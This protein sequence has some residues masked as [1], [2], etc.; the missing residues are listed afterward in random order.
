MEALN[1]NKD[2]E[3]EIQQ[4]GEEQGTSESTTEAEV[5]PVPVVGGMTDEEIEEVVK[6]L[7]RG[8]ESERTLAYNW[9]IQQLKQIVKMIEENETRIL[10]ALH[11]D[12]GKSKTEGFLTE[13]HMALNETKQA[14]HELHS[15]MKPQ[16]VAVPLAQMKGMSTCLIQ[17][18][19]LG[20]VLFI[21]PWNY[22]FNL[23]VNPLLGAIS[24]GNCVLVKP[25]EIS[26][27][28]SNLLAELIPK[29]LDEECVA[30]VEGGVPETTALLKL[31]FDHIFY[32]G[33][34]TV[35]KIVM[36]AAAEHLTP[37]T[38]ELG[39]KSPC[40]VAK[41]ADFEVAAKRI[42]WGKF[43]NC[44]QTCI[45]PD[46]L[47]VDSSVAEEFTKLLVEKLEAFYGT[48]PATSPDYGRIV[49][50]RHLARLQGLLQEVEEDAILAGGKAE[51]ESRYL[52]PTLVKLPGL[53]SSAHLKLMQEEIFGPI[54]PIIPIDDVDVA[55]KFINA[56]PKPLAL[57]LFSNNKTTQQE[58]LDR[59]TSGGCCINETLMHFTCPT[60]P[61][62]GVGE[63][64][65]G[66]YHGKQ[67][68]DTFTH[69][70]SVLNKTTWFDLDVRYPP[71]TEN[72]VWTLKKLI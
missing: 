8:F 19:P 28:T 29:Y 66:S 37:V 30:V 12:L 9:R 40:I 43:L 24:A 45:A 51:A 38:L 63:S 69:K 3:K 4:Q 16:P 61:F 56:N 70:R 41:D 39:G 65:M 32:T 15:W 47:L 31:K 22:P 25:S 58:V 1:N 6:R 10:D 36:R 18:Q 13:V 27:H 50:Q 60:L 21:S 55:I 62:G 44:G 17:P 48:D 20:V 34:G 68:F 59:T 64:G 67:S 35:G 23:C 7:R 53:D 11:K 52:A 57:Y 72:K 42:I 71:Y 49:S 46:Y 2:K 26:V 5:A 33:N 14:I 54:L